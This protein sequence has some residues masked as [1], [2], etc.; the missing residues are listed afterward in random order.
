M[1]HPWVSKIDLWVTDSVMSR[2]IVT[3]L[4]KQMRLP[5]DVEVDSRISHQAL[6]KGLIHDLAKVFSCF[7]LSFCKTV[8]LIILTPIIVNIAIVQAAEAGIC[9]ARMANELDDHKAE[10]HS[11]ERDLKLELSLTNDKK[12]KLKRLVEGRGEEIKRASLE[13]R[14]LKEELD[15]NRDKK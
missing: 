2:L 7:I 10:S 12:D 15:Y 9:I 6:A 8:H 3:H 4:L 11:K 13:K 1:D 14:L 5:L